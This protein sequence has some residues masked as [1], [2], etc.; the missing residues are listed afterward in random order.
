MQTTNCLKIEKIR[1]V[2][3]SDQVKKLMVEKLMVKK[4]K[5]EKFEQVSKCL[6]FSEFEK[7][8]LILNNFSKKIINV[9]QTNKTL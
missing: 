4:S 9:I 2:F 8:M 6:M 1:R 5:K 3:K 7:G